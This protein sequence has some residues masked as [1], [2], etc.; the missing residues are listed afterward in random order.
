[1]TASEISTQRDVPTS[2]TYRKL[3]RR[4]DASILTEKT[5]LGTDS[6][7]ISEYAVAFEEVFLD[8]GRRF[9]VSI[10]RPTRSA[11]EQLA[12]LDPEARKGT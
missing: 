12:G 3:E 8:G 5:A 11:E 4:T 2:T 7:H 9:E 10:T 6:Q 1:M